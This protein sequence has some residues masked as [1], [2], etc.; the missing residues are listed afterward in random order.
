MVVGHRRAQGDLGTEIA[1]GG[2]GRLVAGA[3]QE[4]GLRLGELAA[5]EPPVLLDRLDA[6]AP[7]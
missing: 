6:E 4:G 1:H 3:A 7:E 5:G 2:V